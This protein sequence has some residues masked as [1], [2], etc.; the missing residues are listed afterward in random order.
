M[1]ARST[2]D[3][4]AHVGFL[5]LYGPYLYGNFRKTSGAVNITFERHKVALTALR[6][7]S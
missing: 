6:N 1:G 3:S 4:G 2:D 5:V 7:P